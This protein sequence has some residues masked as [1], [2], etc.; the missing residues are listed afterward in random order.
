MSLSS[1]SCC[2]VLGINCVVPHE[3]RSIDDDLDAFLGDERKLQRHKKLL[4]L[5]TRHVLGRNETPFDLGL[6]AGRRLLQELD[7]DP[8]TFDALICVSPVHDYI[9]TSDG[10][11]LQD[12]LRLSEEAAC[13]DTCGLG[14]TD[15]VYG[16]WLAHS[17]IESGAVKRCLIVEF[18]GSSRFC[19]EKNHHARITFGDAAAAIALERS[20][21]PVPAYFHLKSLGKEWRSIAVPAGGTRLPVDKDILDLT[22]PTAAGDEL[23]LT[24]TFMQGLKVSQFSI[25]EAPRSIATLL[26][27]AN[28]QASDLDFIAIHQAN[29]QIVKVIAGRAKLGA[30]KYSCDAFARYA[31]CGGTSVMVNLCD[32]KGG[33]ALNRVMCVT[34]GV[35]LSLGS[36]ILD[37]SGTKVKPVTVLEGPLERPSREE[38]IKEW[39][40][41]IRTLQ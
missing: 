39:S 29:A 23:K 25:D 10:C 35:G 34:Y 22:I 32:S 20:A 14:C 33:T 2:K 19:S 37:L 7:L 24:D 30:G 6:E 18:S 13:F 21:E 15:C 41:F 40:E 38:Q 26:G 31:N 11:R 28:A 12:A 27:F 1:F 3:L 5:G 16:L 8:L 36:C 9:G 4:G 17:L